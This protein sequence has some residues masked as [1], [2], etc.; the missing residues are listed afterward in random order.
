M[1]P[2][3]NKGDKILIFEHMPVPAALTKMAIP[4]IVSQLITLIYNMADTWFIGQTRRG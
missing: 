3:E 1:Q 4:T 2:K